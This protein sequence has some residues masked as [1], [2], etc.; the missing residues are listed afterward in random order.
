MRFR[1][2]AFEDHPH[3]NEA[4]CHVCGF[5]ALL[6]M[7]AIG[8]MTT[9]GAGAQDMEW[10]LMS[11][12]PEIPPS[13]F[14]GPDQMDDYI[15]RISSRFANNTRERDVFGY[16]KCENIIRRGCGWVP[17]LQIKF[18]DVIPRL[19]VD[20]VMPAEDSFMVGDRLFKKGDRVPINQI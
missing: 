15:K 10:R 12:V 19:R 9:L 11:V 2:P 3:Q 4:V 6:C 7:I 8:G 14:I 16:P 20:A 13:R 5:S 1:Q 18:A 17:N